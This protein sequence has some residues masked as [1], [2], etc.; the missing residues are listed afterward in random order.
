MPIK[1]AH[2]TVLLLPSPSVHGPRTTTIIE[3]VLASW[4][5]RGGDGVA[6]VFVIYYR[7][8]KLNYINM[9]STR[10]AAAVEPSAEHSAG[11]IVA[12][13]PVK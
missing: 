4:T 11:E 12:N 10:V 8:Y 1:L 2:T 5:G 6:R 9:F 3:A 7:G 13:A